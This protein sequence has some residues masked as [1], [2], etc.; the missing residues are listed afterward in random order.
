MR[1]IAL[2][3]LLTPSAVAADPS[4]A[5]VPGPVADHVYAGGW[6]HFVGGGL[7][8]LDCNAD[9]RPDL[10]L[11]GGEKP[12]QLMVNRGGMDFTPQ[13]LP[14]TG[15]ALT[16]VT[17]VY[18]IDLDADGTLDL[19]VMRA[20]PNVAL[21]GLGGCRFELATEALGLPDGGDSWTTA[22]TAWW[23]PGAMRPTLAVGNYVDRADPVGP[24]GACDA[25]A[26]MTPNTEGWM[27]RVLTPG[28]C[29]LS[30][31][32]AQDARG[33]LTL[34][35][36]ND[37][38]YYVHDG[39]EQLWDIAEGRFLGPQDDYDPPMLWGMGIA[40]RDLNRDGRDEVM[41]TSMGDQNLRLARKGGYVDAP[42][43]M[44][45]TAHRPHTGTDGRPS[46]GWHAQFGDVNNDGQA[47]LFI[48]KGNVDQ[49]PGMAMEDPNSLLM[50]Q[51]DGRFVE[52]SVAA[53]VAGTARS[54]GAALVDLDNDGRLDLVVIN[55]R[56]G[57]EL[58]RNVT[59]ETGNWLGVTLR[60]DGG[61]ARAV[62]ARVRVE[63]ADWSEEQ[64]V[65]I[66]GGHAGGVAGPLHFGLG[67]V[68]AV[69]ITVTWPDGTRTRHAPEGINRQ[70]RLQR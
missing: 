64:G 39:A 44:G 5:P 37:R 50:Q 31:L 28:H 46:T 16:S 40:A 12:T 51:A 26:I 18:P 59:S 52:T 53:G 22:F 66:G 10:L 19:F 33:E 14:A 15:G 45:T 61:N 57:A 25:N 56:A 7:S 49:M 24:F 32:A 4:F 2:I 70:V 9:A 42:F 6:E 68:T 65:T 27:T 3:V 60:Q 8:V 23:A 34:R 29:P 62:G 63:G 30:M 1:I 58:Y 47:D 55:R 67:T 35:L 43:E 20:G 54:R 36:S 38:H 69:K 13:P 17:G 11:A 48:A 21:R 41:L